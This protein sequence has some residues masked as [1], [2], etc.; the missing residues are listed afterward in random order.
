MSVQGKSSVS[1]IENSQKSCYNERTFP[2]AAHSWI[3]S[4]INDKNLFVQHGGNK[5]VGI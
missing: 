5:N 2:V 3:G 4:I 1:S